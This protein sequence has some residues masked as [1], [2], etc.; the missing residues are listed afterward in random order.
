MARPNKARTIASALEPVIYYPAGWTATHAS[1]MEVAIEDFEVMRLVDGHAHSVEEAATKVGVS[2]STAG[3]MLERAR[4]AVTLGIERRSAIYVD[5]GKDLRLEA[6][7]T[8]P[9]LGR[10]EPSSLLAVAC[11]ETGEDPEVERIFGRAARFA[12]VGPD[13]QVRFILN[14]GM[15]ASRDA[16]ELAVHALIDAGVGR[17]VAG[18]FGP[19]ALRLISQAGMHAQLASGLRL[20]QVL[21]MFCL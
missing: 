4:R 17:V 3:R 11:P 21:E 1:M 8:R 2:R 5:A 19:D 7:G 12:L 20:G 6:S 15:T 16:A 14:P 10:V 13:G 9:I 18:R